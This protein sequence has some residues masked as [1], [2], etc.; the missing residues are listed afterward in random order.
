MIIT[1]RVSLPAET[2]ESK[3]CQYSDNILQI[4]VSVYT[5][6]TW[7]L[8]VEPHKVHRSILCKFYM[9]GPKFENCVVQSL[10]PY[11]RS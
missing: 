7:N 1:K 4:T 9:P 10:P 6:M 3:R 11:R 2:F 5:Q 8:V